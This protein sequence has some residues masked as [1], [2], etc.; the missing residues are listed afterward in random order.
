MAIAEVLAVVTGPGQEGVLGVGDMLASRWDG[1]L[2]VL[3][4]SNCRSPFS[5]IQF[6]QAL[7]GRN[8]WRKHAS[9]LPEIETLCAKSSTAYVQQLSLG[10]KRQCSAV[11]KRSWPNMRC[12]LT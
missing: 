2:T 6:T 7:C 1:R 12:T 10:T 4:L 3:L 8:W 9:A 11:W 5:A